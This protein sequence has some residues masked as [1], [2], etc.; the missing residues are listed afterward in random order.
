MKKII[1]LNDLNVEKCFKLIFD[2]KSD[3]EYFSNLGWSKNQFLEQIKKKIKFSF[4]L[5]NYDKLV[6]FIIGDLITIEKKLEYEILLI[7]VD[8]KYR[9]KGNATLLLDTIIKYSIDNNL[10][11]ICLEVAQS[12]IGA[13][14]L[15][16]K[17][18]FIRVGYRK[19][20]YRLP[21]LEKDNCII[22]EKKFND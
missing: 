12:N 13:I 14:S 21:S 1:K 4:C 10:N 8:T 6:G 7:Y 15:Y 5:N 2:N 9:N 19:N 16:E 22:Y 18:K 17:N 11:R 20:Y 3:Y